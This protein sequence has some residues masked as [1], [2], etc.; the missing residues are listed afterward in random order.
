ME[1][2]RQQQSNKDSYSPDYDPLGEVGRSEL[3]MSR[4][5]T[6]F[7]PADKD[8]SLERDLSL[9]EYEIDKD[10][11]IQ[12]IKDY[13]KERRYDDAQELVYKYR[14]AA[15]ID[16]N[17]AMLARLTAQG[18]EKQ[19][20]IAKVE[21]I[22]DA[23]PDD[24]YQMR[25]SLYR[26][27][28]KIDPGNEHYQKELDASLIAMGVDLSGGN[29]IA[30]TNKYA[31]WLFSPGALIWAII[32]GLWTAGMTSIIYEQDGLVPALMSAFVILLNTWLYS[33]HKSSPIAKQSTVV[34]VL[35][36]IG[37]WIVSFITIAM[38]CSI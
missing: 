16:E 34:K 33:N 12:A 38:I 11:I 3:N 31:I 10:F 21:T 6:L 9:E 37:V 25:V 2:Q 35:V 27:I 22:L 26:R 30:K 28:L 29:K 24:D 14:A 8:R 4:S 23:T 19:S 36:N 32:S 5:E 1:R 17:F 15:K 13:L 7:T 18:L 20:K